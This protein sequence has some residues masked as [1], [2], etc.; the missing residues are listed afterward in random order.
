MLEPILTLIFS[1]AL[2]VASPYG[3]TVTKARHPDTGEMVA[4]KK[5]KMPGDEKEGLGGM[6][7]IVL[8]E[9]KGLRELRHENIVN[10]L[11]VVTSKPGDRNR[12]RGEVFMV[13]E[14]C[15]HDLSG[16]LATPE[17]EITPALLRSYLHQLLTAMAHMHSKGWVHRDLKTANILVTRDNVLKVADLGLARSLNTGPS[18][19]FSTFQLV[20]PWYRAPELI[21]GD[22]NG[23]GAAIDIW[24]VGCIFAELLTRQPL[25]T[26]DDNVQLIRQIYRLLG[27][28]D[29]NAASGP[30]SSP[31][32]AAA[33]P[34]SAGAGSAASSSSSSSSSSS[35]WPG[36]K[37]LK[38]WQTFKPRS[39]HTNQLRTKFKR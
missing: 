26:G 8:R 13:F 28:P 5:L 32:S 11:E 16:L 3:S 2:S 25:F 22:P 6:P 20:T 18:R 9:I 31:T 17:F 7:L 38:G 21:Y 15:E 10:L 4:I 24:S 12:Q 27:A 39:Q 30:A 35:G 23:C 1:L 37:N 14:Y 19:Q 34:S 33:V 29:P 36:L